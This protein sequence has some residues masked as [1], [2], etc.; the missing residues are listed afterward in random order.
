MIKPQST[1]LRKLLKF[2]GKAVLVVVLFM[3]ILVIYA[4]LK[5]KWVKKQIEVFSG[6]VVIGQP[7]AGLENKAKEMHLKYRRMT[8]SNEK[9]GRFYVWEGA[10]FNRWFC[11]VEYKDGKA[12]NKKVTLVD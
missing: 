12:L 11:D 2:I 10:F 5:V 7:V 6:L 4:E 9:D 3:F 8:D 1:L